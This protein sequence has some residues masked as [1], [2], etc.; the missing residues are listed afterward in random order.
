M[1]EDQQQIHLTY[2]QTKQLAEGLEDYRTQYFEWHCQYAFE[3]YLKDW[4]PR[5]LPQDSSYAAVIVETRCNPL[6]EFSIKNTLLFTPNEV[7][8]QIFC[9]LQN[10]NFVENIVKNIQYTKVE[11]LPDVETLSKGDYSKLL[12]NPLF[13]QAIPA[14]KLLMFQYDTL[15]T[16]YLDLSFFEYPYL[17][18]PWF[19]GEFIETFY[20]NDDSETLQSSQKLFFEIRRNL[21][22][23]LIDLCP[24]GFGNGG[25]SIRHKQVILEICQAYPDETDIAED[26]YFS[27]F[28]YQDS[29]KVP[30]L[31]IARKFSTETDF[32]EDSVGIHASW[33][34]LSSEKQAYFFE[35]HLKNLLVAFTLPNSV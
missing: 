15:L 21:N 12:K 6:L 3:K 19:K 9:S 1:S 30:D 5:S 26:V 13:W 27:Y 14:E 25:L 33:K 28:V 11:I 7:G 35:K 8:L 10:L 22:K 16:E 29:D 31:E 32:C 23:Q 34:F 20:L 24:T 18:S 4:Q 2:Q 17:G